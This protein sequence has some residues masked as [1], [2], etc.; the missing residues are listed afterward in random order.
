MIWAYWWTEKYG[1]LALLLRAIHSVKKKM[2]DN[3]QK[4]KYNKRKK[5]KK[6]F[7]LPMGIIICTRYAVIHIVVVVVRLYA[8]VVT[9]ILYIQCVDTIVHVSSFTRLIC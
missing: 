4:Q 6:L 7:R 2:N 9:I 8:N 3:V 5:K 1:R